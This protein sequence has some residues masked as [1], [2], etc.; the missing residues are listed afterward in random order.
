VMSITN[1]YF[2]VCVLDL[3]EQMLDCDIRLGL[4]MQMN[5]KDF[6]LFT[7]VVN[8]N[9]IRKISGGNMSRAMV[10]WFAL[11][12]FLLSAQSG[13]A[14][15]K[16]T[17]KNGQQTFSGQPCAQNAQI[18]KV[19]THTP[20]AA[21]MEKVKTEMLDL[22]SGLSDSR[23]EREIARLQEEIRIKQR[24]RDSALEVIR[25]KQSTANN[26]IAGA[27]YY[28]GLATEMQA[29]TAQYKSEIDILQNR[30]EEIRKE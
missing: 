25:Y 4:Y 30:I 9:S 6:L 24:E 10:Q 17:D 16:C 1:S 13:A 14:V 22:E 3:T 18:V 21:E 28:A 20:S 12:A 2:F 5:E 29:V 19:Q 26:N 8:P 27:Q 7:W 11:V 15:Y 23:K